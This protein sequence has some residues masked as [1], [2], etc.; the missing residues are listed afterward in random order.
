MPSTQNKNEL[1]SRVRLLKLDSQLLI[2]YKNDMG[3]RVSADLSVFSGLGEEV[4]QLITPILRYLERIRAKSRGFYTLVLVEIGRALSVAG[5]RS[6][7]KSEMEWQDLI[8]TTY[9]HIFT[10]TR[11]SA[12]LKSRTDRAQAAI[13][14]LR[15]LQDEGVIPLGVIFPSTRTKQEPYTTGGPETITSLIGDATPLPMKTTTNKLL[16]AIRL[17]RSDAEYLDEI[18]E[19]LSARRACLR[20][21]LIDYWEALKG[22][23]NFGASAISSVDW[24]NLYILLNKSH[25]T[26]GVHPCDPSTQ[27]GLKN[28]LALFKKLFDGLPSDKELTALYKKGWVPFTNLRAA[29]CGANLPNWPF[30]SMNSFPEKAKVHRLRVRWMLG[31]LSYDDVGVLSALL[32]MEHP[33]I[34][35]ESAYHA[36]IVDRHGKH[37]LEFNDGAYYFSVHKHRAKSLKGECLSPLAHQIV[38]FASTLNLAERDAL[39]NKGD[40][41]GELLFLPFEQSRG[42]AVVTCASQTYVSFLSGARN[43]TRPQAVWLGDFCPNLLE[44]GLERKT[45]T[46]KRIRDSEGV[47]E[48]FRT[49]SITAVTK[50]LGNTE[51]VVIDHYIPQAL[52]T[53][54]LTRLIRRYQN[55]WIATAAATEPFLL[56]VTDFSTV[57]QLNTFLSD[58]LV[59]HQPNSSNFA[60]IMH[61][62]FKHLHISSE[63]W[64]TL[65]PGATLSIS[66]SA[67]SLASLYLYHEAASDTG[68]QIHGQA[69]PTENLLEI[70]ALL[71][72]AT[73]LKFKLPDHPNSEF[74]TAHHEACLIAE[75][76]R[77]RMNWSKLFCGVK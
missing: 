60:G 57:E 17:D 21:A 15:H 61:Q 29:I 30:P 47:L 32:V 18:R 51:K 39:I 44:M 77:H 12:N 11:T 10:N 3:V 7:P 26:T 4:T 5:Y 20:T 14:L 6:I 8:M 65:E 13:G 62:R 66:I 52:L 69:Q 22:H 50:K 31:R 48:W 37:M 38:D 1:D 75:S 33:R 36:R 59:Q 43:S 70:R 55:L 74:R 28:L 41:R 64:R 16:C 2:T 23:V 53:S 76:M 9:F 49:G 56:D 73:V 40:V 63:E 54:W 34:N 45:I 27:Q 46:L 19:A 71:D 42:K 24:D 68:L 67:S 58:M 25:L 35:P 72:L